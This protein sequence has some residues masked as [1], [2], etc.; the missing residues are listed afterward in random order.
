MTA[1]LLLTSALTKFCEK[2]E[3][4]KTEKGGGGFENTET[5]PHDETYDVRATSF[6]SFWD[7]EGTPNADRA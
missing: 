1:L 5:Q 3:G 6:C 7:G 2:G 4:L